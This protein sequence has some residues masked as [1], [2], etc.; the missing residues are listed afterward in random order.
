MMKYKTV[1]YL[2]SPF[3]HFKGKPISYYSQL[4][5]FIPNDPVYLTTSMFMR[6]QPQNR[7]VRV[8]QQEEDPTLIPEQE[9]DPV[10][11]PE[12]EEDQEEEIEIEEPQ[13]EILIHPMAAMAPVNLTKF[14]GS[15]NANL[16]WSLWTRLTA[17]MKWDQAA[18]TNWF[19]L[20][21]EKSATM[22][23]GSLPETTRS[24]ATLLEAAFKARYIQQSLDMAILSGSQSATETVATYVD[25]M[26]MAMD[27][28]NIPETVLVTVIIKGLKPAIK[29]IVMP[30]DP[31]TFMDLLKSA[32]MAEQ[33][34]QETHAPVVAV[35]TPNTDL[36]DLNSRIDQLT[37]AVLE[38]RKTNGSD[39][40]RNDGQRWTGPTPH[41]QQNQHSQPRLTNPI[42]NNGCKNC[43]KSSCFV[44]SR[45]AA[46]GQI[47][48]SCGK[49]NHFGRVCRS[50]SQNS[51][52]FSFP[53]R[54]N[55]QPSQQVNQPSHQFSQPNQQFNQ[56]QFS[57]PNQQF[58]QRQPQ[59][60]FF[61]PNNQRQQPYSQ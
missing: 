49:L 1:T 26:R 27:G 50:V 21:L 58:N 41:Q 61:P 29:Q 12:Q 22:W 24:D 5:S 15:Q 16:W 6:K 11:I 2:E 47:C 28:H 17:A 34:L 42:S 14:D 53:Q 43:G 32:R 55:N 13:V 18:A 44:K 54:S 3:L 4:F 36:A 10:L 30:Q 38:I 39:G 35:T 48:Y 37:K 23:Y 56:R 59:Q 31:T 52:Q 57:Q 19:P 46:Q 40:Q 51:Q 60:P 45:C 7:L 8:E 9:E 33:V 25:R 20:Y